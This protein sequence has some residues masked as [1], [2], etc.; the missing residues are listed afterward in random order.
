MDSTEGV[1]I[2]SVILY[3][4]S[5]G[6]S[7]ASLCRSAIDGCTLVHLIGFEKIKQMDAKSFS[8]DFFLN[9]I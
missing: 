6:S 7:F 8:N 1:L 5:L 3:Y 2:V 9:I 4:T